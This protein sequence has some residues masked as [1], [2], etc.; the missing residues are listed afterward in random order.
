MLV[1]STE[2]RTGREGTACRPASAQQSW[3]GVGSTQLVPY[4]WFSINCTI[5]P[6]L[7]KATGPWNTLNSS[8]F[9]EF[10][11]IA[12]Q[13][14]VQIKTQFLILTCCFYKFGIGIV[15]DDG[16][17][18]VSEIQFKGSSDDVYVWIDVGR[19]ICLFTIWK[20][21]NDPIPNE[22]LISPS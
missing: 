9:L 22:D 19:Y 3:S 13:N 16:N 18:Q 20:T 17:G 21:I 7:G 10:K 2:E 11:S 8:D 5:V 12:L 6:T 4:A 15:G 14:L 1:L